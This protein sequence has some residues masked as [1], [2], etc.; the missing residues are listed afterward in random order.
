MDSK[1]PEK[2]VIKATSQKTTEDDPNQGGRPDD[3]GG[4][5]LDTPD[6]ESKE[7]EDKCSQDDREGSDDNSDD[8]SDYNSDDSIDYDY[9]PDPTVSEDSPSHYSKHPSLPCY[10]KI[11]GVSYTP[12]GWIRKYKKRSHK[13]TDSEEPVP[14]KLKF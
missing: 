7:D 13:E 3:L 5:E 12:P 8:N 2:A 6:D 1:D 4:D 14:K 9:I 10:C 11:R